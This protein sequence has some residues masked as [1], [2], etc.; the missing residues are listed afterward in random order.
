MNKTF[1]SNLILEPTPVK[2]LTACSIDAKLRVI[3]YDKKTYILDLRYEG[4]VT[5]RL[6]CK[7]GEENSL[8]NADG[9]SDEIKAKV[10][11]YLA[12]R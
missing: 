10:N 9:V 4:E 5:L 7:Q 6:I 3:R 11:E 1:I 8:I 12:A 2:G